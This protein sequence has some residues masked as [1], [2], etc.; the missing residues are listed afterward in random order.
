MEM[1]VFK[2]ID[3]HGSATQLARCDTHK[4]LG[5]AMETWSRRSMIRRFIIGSLLESGQHWTDSLALLN[6]S[7]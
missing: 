2:G 6:H 1:A 4:M 5:R 3:S 7:W